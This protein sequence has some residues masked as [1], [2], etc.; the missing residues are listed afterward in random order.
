VRSSCVRVATFVALV[1]LFA[2]VGFA[3]TPVSAETPSSPVI[4]DAVAWLTAQQEAD[5]GFEL[6]N[7]QGFETPD[8]ILAIAEAGQTGPAW[9]TAEAFA[10][11]SATKYQGT[12]DTPLDAVDDWIAKPGGVNPGEAAKIILL[13]V[14][15]LGLD[16][17][18]FG[19]ADTDLEAI[20]YHAGC[21]AAPDTTG[22]FFG[23]ILL[24]ALGGN[25]LCGAP[26]PALITQIRD[27][28]RADG[29]WNFLG[30]PDDNPFPADSD[31][32]TTTSAILAILSS[33]AAW[34][35]P[36]VTAGLRFLS[37][38][39]DPATGAF[40]GFGFPDPNATATS[41]FAIAAAG[42]DPS[43]D[44]WRLTVDPTTAVTPYLDPAAYLRSLQ[45]QDGAI[46][47]PIPNTFATS[48]SVEALL[49]SWWPLTRAT[50]A[51]DCAP[52]TPDPDPDPD[53]GS[54]EVV[55]SPNVVVVQPNF[56]G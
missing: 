15:P 53:P 18:A 48:Q 1:S 32:D 31:V 5:G 9:S 39:Y 40:K 45:A 20:V 25:L 35:D 46:V 7:F 42:F 14:A 19:A 17:T 38:Q 55:V 49:L 22:V 6:S 26:Y 24:V 12:G 36:A 27:G 44:C 16:P 47:G 29:G 23:E 34:D 56:T 33:G 30:S 13:V 10:A 28:Q 4:A 3:A 54:D 50:G 41:M 51:P 52:P 37:Q 8:A 2:S 43:S 11:V 21:G